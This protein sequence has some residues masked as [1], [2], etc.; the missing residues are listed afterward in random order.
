MV[1]GAEHVDTQV[2][3]AVA[4]VLVVGD[5]AGDVG[6]LAV[7][8]D[9]DTIL[10]VAV[11]GGPQPPRAVGLVQV[12]VGLEF[13]DA[14][15]HQARREHGVLVGVDIEVG[16]ELV[17]AGLD[18]VEHQ[19]HAL[20]AEGLDPLGLGEVEDTGGL[21]DDLLGDVDDVLTGIAVLGCGKALRGRLQRP[22][23][24]VDLGA[25]VVEVV[26][27]G[28]L[29][30]AGGQDASECVADRGPA[31]STEVDRAGRVGGHELEVDHLVGDLVAAAVVLPLL[32][33]G[34]DDGVLCG[35]GQP[36]VDESGACDLGLLDALG[37]GEGLGQPAGEITGHDAEALAEL[38]CDVGGI[39]TVIGA[40][41]ALDHDR[42]GDQ[43][44]VEAMVG[45]DTAGHSA[46]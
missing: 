5:V 37:G 31:G 13:G 28:D 21:G 7:A 35:G 2:E 4:L 24:A 19:L 8:L 46:Q 30:A 29:R 17:Q 39:V 23:E 10:V 42:I 11:V 27:A 3:A 41:W 1:I 38:E 44:G 14:A 6:G 43:R 45:D 25:V 16:A 22:G 9:D 18:V 32:E 34:G 26:L 40:A 33:H 36:D 12:A 20:R 15:I